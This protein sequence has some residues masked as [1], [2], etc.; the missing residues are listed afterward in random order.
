M[1]RLLTTILTTC[2][3]S[4]IAVA[5]EQDA[6]ELAHKLSN[7]MAAVGSLNLLPDFTGFTG[8]LPEAK[9]QS[10]FSITFQPSLPKPGVLGFN[11]LFR[12]AIPILFSQPYYDSDAGKFEKAGFNLGNIGFDLALGKTTESGRLYFYGIVGDIPAATSS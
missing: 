3:I 6:D 9:D 1:K 5:Q 10:S 7:P 4:G 8:D 11:L 12:P 2:L